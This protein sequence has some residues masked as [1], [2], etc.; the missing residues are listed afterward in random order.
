MPPTRRRDAVGCIADGC[1]RHQLFEYDLLV[2]ETSDR[3]KATAAQVKAEHL[4]TFCVVARLE[5]VS[6]AAAS[7]GLS[8]PAVSRQLRILED[9]HGLQLYERTGMGIALT[10]AGHQ[11]LP[12]ACEVHDSL[13]MVRRFLAG[14]LP[15]GHA[16][17]RVGLSHHLTTRYTGAVLEAA[18]S[19]A[20]TGSELEVHLLEAYS[21]DLVTQ[22]ADG[23]L[24]AAYILLAEGLE[25]AGLQVRRLGSERLTLLVKPDDPIALQP[26]LPL[27]AL[28]G[29]TLVVP[30]SASEVYRRVRE[31]IEKSGLEPG[32][33]LEVSGPSAVR[34]AVMGGL[35]IGVTVHSFA[36]SDI[37]SGALI[38][39]EPE[40]RALSVDVG[41]VARHATRMFPWQRRALDA[42]RAHVD[43]A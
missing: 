4:F 17:M 42:I 11:L 16:S 30:S 37:R 9:A 3:S 6:R 23:R 13:R 39:I 12:Y 8:Q 2:S 26:R 14:E 38:A 15:P 32:R 18:R 28:V 7:I 29:E 10:A 27:A 24:D 31:A 34:G 41:E 19:H 35:G 21:R 40:G 1:P 20:A 43:R 25:L 22:V 33:V 36:A 5:S